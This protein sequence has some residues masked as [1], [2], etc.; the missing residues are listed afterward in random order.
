MEFRFFVKKCKLSFVDMMV[1]GNHV[2]EAEVEHT[3]FTLQVLLRHVA[4]I[5]T[6]FCFLVWLKVTVVRFELLSM[7]L[8]HQ[9]VLIYLVDEMM[10]NEHK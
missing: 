6:W 7:Q 3:F 10:I 8:I 1:N 5:T 2:A 9:K 4:F